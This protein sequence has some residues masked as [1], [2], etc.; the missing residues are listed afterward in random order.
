M[1]LLAAAFCGFAKGKRKVK[2]AKFYA[3]KTSR[4]FLYKHS[5]REKNNRI[6]DRLKENYKINVYTN[7]LF[8][9][10][11]FLQF[12]LKSTYSISSTN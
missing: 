10:F 3:R 6:S 9:S 12:T 7:V 1:C 2:Q 11:L 5:N 8:F 4:L